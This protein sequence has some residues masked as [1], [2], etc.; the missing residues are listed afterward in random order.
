MTYLLKERSVAAELVTG[1]TRE[2]TRRKLIQEFRDGRV[3]VLCNCSVLTTGFDAPKITHVVIARPTVSRV[4][5]EQMVGRG[6]RG[7]R[8]GGTAECVIIDCEDVYRKWPGQPQLGFE[9][10]R[11]LWKP[12]KLTRPK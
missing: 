11:H 4:L 2:A 7:P 6:L 5:Y 12:K 8:F 1:E 10:F 3:K 9:A